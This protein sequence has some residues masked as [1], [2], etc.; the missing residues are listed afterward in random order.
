LK[1]KYSAPFELTYTDEGGKKQE[2]IMGCY[3]IGI[4]RLMGVITEV[5]HDDRGVVWPTSV[6]PFAVH[7][8]ELGKGKGEAIY[9]A[10][11]AKG[12]DVLYDDRDAS[13][14]EKFADADLIGIPWR[15]LVSE[16]TGAQVEVKRRGT[17]RSTLMDL[18]DALKT[19]NA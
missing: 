17:D 3:G 13:A 18:A 9:A 2:V 7:L 4:S 14:G 1:T 19:V 8:V 12:I 15:I 6:A 16:K 10:L 11:Q 5:S